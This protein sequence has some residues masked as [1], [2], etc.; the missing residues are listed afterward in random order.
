MSL[1]AA[2]FDVT[3]DGFM[4]AFIHMKLTIAIA[5]SSALKSSFFLTSESNDAK[6][7]GKA[8]ERLK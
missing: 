7:G 3:T 2:M 4:F 6:S 8:V 5:G 1:F